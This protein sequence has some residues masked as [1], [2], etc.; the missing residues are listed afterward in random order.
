MKRAAKKPPII[1]KVQNVRVM[2]FAFFFS[3]SDCCC[4]AGVGV[5]YSSKVSKLSKRRYDQG[6]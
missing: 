1:T 2:K 4:S 6:T 5:F 3:Y